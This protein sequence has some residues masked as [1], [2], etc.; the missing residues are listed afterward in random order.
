MDLKHFIKL[1]D[2][3]N[4]FGGIE[5]NDPNLDTTGYIEV[6]QANTDGSNEVENS[7]ENMIQQEEE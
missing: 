7:H 1:N 2:D 6:T 3:V 4:I 5:T